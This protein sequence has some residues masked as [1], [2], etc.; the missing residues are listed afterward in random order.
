MNERAEDRI[1]IERAQ[2]GLAAAQLC[3][4]K[5]LFHSATSRAYYA[6]F[7]AAQVALAAIGV[8]RSKWNHSD[9]QST[10]ATEL[11]KRRKRY[12]NHFGSHFNETLR[13]RIEADYRRKGISRKN[14]TQAVGWAREF[15]TTIIAKETAHDTDSPDRR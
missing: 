5:N 14:A 11:V 6:M 9:L 4:E 12:P 7:W 13:L 2:E 10:F 8:R 15:V 1:F 3:L